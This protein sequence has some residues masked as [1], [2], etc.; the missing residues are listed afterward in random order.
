MTAST[1]RTGNRI[2]SSAAMDGTSPTQI[3]RRVWFLA[4]RKSLCDTF[5][6]GGTMVT[7]IVTRVR[8]RAFTLTE[9]L[10]VIG[11]IAV[12]I[13]LL[14]PALGKARATANATACLSNL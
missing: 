11:L 7:R 10:V 2:P 1:H 8:H 12:L 9:L 4:S 6:P 13:S 14:L 5:L 3:P